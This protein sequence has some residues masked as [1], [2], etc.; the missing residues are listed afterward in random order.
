VN[1]STYKGRVFVE[2]TTNGD[3]SYYNR[4]VDP[5]TRN[6]AFGRSVANTVNKH[7]EVGGKVSGGWGPVKAEISAN[8]GESYTKAATR[9]E[10][11]S[12]T[13]TIRPKHTGWVRAISYTKVVY[14]QAKSER[15]NAAKEKCVPTV[16]SRAFWGA[17]MIQ[18]VPTTKKGHHFPGRQV[19]P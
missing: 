3:I 17:P 16:I 1:S 2:D 7:W 4:T 19:L 13:M 9:T 8:Y 18:L 6:L 11:D 5:V 10:S 14:W 15:W 12:I